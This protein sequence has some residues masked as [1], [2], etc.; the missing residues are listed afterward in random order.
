MSMCALQRA[1]AVLQ[2]CWNPLVTFVLL[3]SF[4]GAMEEQAAKQFPQHKRWPVVLHKQGW[5]EAFKE[6]HKS[7]IYLT[8]DAE[9][10]VES[11]DKDHAYI[12]GGIVDRNRYPRLCLEKANDLGIATASLPITEHLKMRGSKVRALDV[13]HAWYAQV[14]DIAHMH[15]VLWM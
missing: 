8:A 9:R 14:V 11:L 10:Q 15:Y 1:R 3:C 5:E 13:A 2:M 6:S 4:D 7:L 12:I